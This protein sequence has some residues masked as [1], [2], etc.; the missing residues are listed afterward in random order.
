[1]QTYYISKEMIEILKKNSF[2]LFIKGRTKALL[3]QI[4]NLFYMQELTTVLMN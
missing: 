2:N 4:D 3:E 1:M